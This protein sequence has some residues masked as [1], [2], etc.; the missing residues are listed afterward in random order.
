MQFSKQL[1]F[2]TFWV[3]DPKT[4]FTNRLGM[5]SLV[6][7]K[8]IPNCCH[9]QADDQFNSNC[10]QT[11]PTLT[12]SHVQADDQFNS[13]CVQ[14]RP[15]L[16][17]SHVQ[18]DDQF[19]SVFKPGLPSHWVMCKQMTSLILM[20]FKPGLPSHWAMPTPN[21]LNTLK[22][23]QFSNIDLPLQLNTPLKPLHNLLL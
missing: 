7:K 9:V 23:V 22:Y 18:A 14:T 16:T 15:T 20:V 11:R 21:N 5:Q 19:N 2:G 1:H 17:F 8:N 4:D 13:N 3:P 12:F 6:I 10:V